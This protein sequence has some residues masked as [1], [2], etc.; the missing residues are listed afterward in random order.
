M[1][2]VDKILQDVNYPVN[3]IK[4]VKCLQAHNEADWIEYNLSNCYDEFDKI[5]VLEGAVE[6][7]PN[8]T[9][10]GHS[11]DGTLELIKSFPDP[12]NKIELY[13]LNRPFK[14][15]EQMKQVF[16]DVASEDEFLCIAD[17]DEFFLEGQINRIR[18]ILRARPN[19]SQIVPMFLHF[20]RDAYHIRNMDTNYTIQHQRF[21]R[22][23][24]GMRYHSHPVA[25]DANGICTYFDNSY[26]PRKFVPIPPL[27]IYHYGHAKGPEAFKAKKTFYD[28]ELAKFSAEGGKTAAQAFDDNFREFIEYK[29]KPSDV[30]YFDAPHPK[31]MEGHPILKYREPFFE[32]KEISMQIR[33]WKQDTIYA[34]ENVPLIAVW[35]WREYQRQQPLY[36]NLRVA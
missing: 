34:E 9:P 12:A 2:Q 16:L 14:S 27:Y 36:N 19:L 35:M 22:Y 17:A 25:T 26:Q 6:G 10:D 30:L 31:A 23:T 32:Q 15:L 28:R 13:T 3:N 8:S 24:K 5:R 33:N 21:I 1:K 11:T 7:R 29:E 20:W 4:L 18:R